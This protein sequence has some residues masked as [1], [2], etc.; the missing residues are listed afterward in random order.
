MQNN[1]SSI[2]RL[3]HSKPNQPIFA[4]RPTALEN[5]A[6]YF[7]KNFQGK[8]MYAVKTN[9]EKHILQGLYRQG[10]S[11]FDVSSLAEIDLIHSLFP[12]A[13]LFFMHPVK[14]RH[15]IREAYNHY[16]VRN[17][18]LDCLDE[19]NKILQETHYADDL[20][21]FVR[22]AIPNTYAEHN[23]GEKF[24]A[25]LQQAISLVK[26]TKRFSKKL[27]ICFHVGSQC[28]HPNAYRI[29]MK[30]VAAL[31]EETSIDIDYIDVGGGFPSVYPGMIPPPIIEYFNAI[32]E[33]FAKLNKKN[34][35]ELLCEPGRALVAESTSVVVRVEMRKGDKLYIN[36]GTYGSLF[37]AGTPH[38]IFPVKLLRH[39]AS[40]PLHLAP[41]SF[42]GPTCDTL[43][44]MKGPFYLPE[45]ISE[46]DYIEIGQL[47]AY[48][49]VLATRFNGFSHETETVII[50]DPPLMTLYGKETQATPFESAELI[51]V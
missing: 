15:D 23:L 20:T 42:Y 32:H 18:S 49:R 36:D 38:M 12:H 10:I 41:Y 25:N 43:D 3:A 19:L 30:L 21:L 39:E 6:K 5:A 46:G 14:S 31:I 40:D 16:Y 48:A 7:V 11:A 27:G 1:F 50:N 17:F 22:L 8:I 44:F 29:A 34:N 9:P 28:M 13:Q 51:A 26:E 4:F 33:E 45:D 2:L 37:D 47:G 35:I 24:G